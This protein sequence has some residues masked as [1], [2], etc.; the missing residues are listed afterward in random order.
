MTLLAHSRLN[1]RW[2]KEAVML[3]G[4][5]GEIPIGLARVSRRFERWRSGHKSRLPIPNALWKAA[6]EAAREHEVFRLAE[7]DR[8]RPGGWRIS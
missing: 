3:V 1:G 8:R 7:K 5:T 6:T 4:D 2:G